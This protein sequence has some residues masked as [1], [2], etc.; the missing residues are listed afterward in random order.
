[1]LKISQKKSMKNIFLN[2]VKV[3]QVKNIKKV[4]KKSF[5]DLLFL[6]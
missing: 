2:Q 4:N 1:M 6:N 5:L 3:D